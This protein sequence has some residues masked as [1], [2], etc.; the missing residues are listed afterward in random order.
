MAIAY[1]SYRRYYPPLRS[2]RCDEPYPSR[3]AVTSLNGAGKMRDEEQPS[4]A[5]T[6]FA[7]DDLVDDLEET[8]PLHSMSRSTSANNPRESG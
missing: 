7:L 3:A 1:F 6:N 2:M 8:D 5:E 4:L